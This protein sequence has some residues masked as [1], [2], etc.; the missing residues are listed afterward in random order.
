MLHINLI[1][2]FNKSR[3]ITTP[4]ILEKRQHPYQPTPP[5]IMS[6]LSLKVYCMQNFPVFH[7]IESKIYHKNFGKSEIAVPP[8]LYPN[9]TFLISNNT[10]CL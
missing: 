3:H 8:Q 6:M 5:K 1:F 4:K 9:C 7:A 2:L 10:F